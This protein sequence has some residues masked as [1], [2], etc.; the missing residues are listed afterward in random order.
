MR[1]PQILIIDDNQYLLDTISHILKREGFSHDTTTSPGQGLEWIEER[2]YDLVISDM[3]MP[4]MTGLELIKMVKVRRPETE[5]I[6]ITGFGSIDSSVRAMSLGAYHYL[7]K[8]FNHDELILIIKRAL[9]KRALARDYEL[10]KQEIEKRYSFNSIV[11]QNEQMQRIYELI[12]KVGPSNAP[13]LIQGES[14]TGKELIARAIHQRSKRHNKRFLAINTSSLP[15]TLLESEL[16]GYKKGAFTGATQDRT[17]LLATT[18]GG[19]VFLDEVSSMSK[20]FQGKLL[21]VIQES[22]IIPV[23]GSKSVPI[24]VRFI[25]ASNRYLKELVLEGVFREDLF[26]RLNVIEISIPPLRERLDDIILLAEHFLRKF[27]EEQGVP[28]K[29]F[30][31]NVLKI[32]YSHDWPGNVRELENTVRRAVIM[33]DS[34]VLT[35]KDIIIRRLD[36]SQMNGMR[37]TGNFMS[38]KYDEAKRKVSESFQREYVTNLLDSSRGNISR[39][40]ERA[41]ITRQALYRLIKK[42]RIPIP[43]QHA[44]Q[45]Q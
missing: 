44:P 24:D 1:S 6:F 18:E 15:E 37:S 13:I 17:G 36:R 45:I 32:L 38:M 31:K 41:G 29:K 9:A 3:R 34:K 28:P 30:S 40:A 5:V 22:E 8:P 26:Y 39:A 20:A 14:G 21:R 25:S 33:S 27:C 16:F 23:G 4:E 35:S 11:G 19:S 2:D 7:T 42:H 10:L 43:K 12:K